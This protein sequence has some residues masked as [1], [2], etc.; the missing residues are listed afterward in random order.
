MRRDGTTPRRAPARTALAAALALALLAALA[1]SAASY[2][3][4]PWFRPGVPYDDNFPDP[5]IVVHNGRYYAYGTSTGGAYLPV[6]VSDDL[7]TWVPR[8]A[9][10]PGVP[11]ID[12]P[13]FNDALPQPA[14][15]AAD[16]PGAGRMSKE[17]W[18]PGVARINGRFVAFYA[19]RER[20]DR[21]RFCISVATSSSPIGPFVDNTSGPLVCDAD[22]NG[23]NDPFPFVDPA[24]GAAYLIWKSEG[25]P[26][27]TPTRIWSRQLNGQGTGFAAGSQRHLLLQTDRAWEGNV[28]ENPS[29]VRHAGTLHLFYSAN[30]WQSAYYA[31]GHATCA[32]PLHGCIKRGFDGIVHT[33]EGDRLGPGGPAPFV[34]LQNRLRLG[35]HAWNA[36]YTSYPAYPQCQSAGTCRSQ[37]QRR[38]YVDFV[39]GSGTDIGIG[40]TNSFSDIP[41]G[42]FYTEPVRWLKA[43]GITTGIGGGH[44]FGPDLPVTRGEMA[45]F[46]W[47]L[48]GEPGTAAGQRFVDVRPGIFY[49]RPVRWLDENR[50]TTGQGGSNRF[51]PDA[52]V[53]RGEMATFLW[54][55]AGTPAPSGG[56][57]FV[58]VRVGAFY[59]TAI[60]WL[61]QTGITTG[62]GGSNRFAPDAR[63]TRGEM[64]AFLQRFDQ[65]GL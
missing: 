21:D 56:Q 16:R 44:R 8:P 17:V 47:R 26:G 20:L 62:V 37:G 39:L 5:N 64:A 58:D 48:R 22:P 2:P 45:T 59:D 46:L 11:G 31:I 36:P 63:V 27:S 38:L 42:A 52:P 25:I 7:R 51:A 1:P 29:M 15:W 54:R 57:R 60:R 30:E 10:D 28:I 23:S 3:G 6:M 33:S 4:A 32:S 43:R 34:D 53:T 24:T 9:Y 65:R 19:V 14:A 18:A 55:L 50:I 13:Y 35:Y 40:R 61:A 41:P 49:D 12:D